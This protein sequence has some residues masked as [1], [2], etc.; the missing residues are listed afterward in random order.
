MAEPVI[1]FVAPATLDPQSRAALDGMAA[2]LGFVPASML[3]YFHR[4]PIAN[5]IM[6]LMGA[7]FQAPDS[8]LPSALKGKLGILCS[9]IN[10]CAY[11]VSHQCHAGGADDAAL[12][13]LVS[14][15]D[16]GGDAVERAC[17]AY[18]RAASFDPASVDVA[19][20]EELKAVLSPAQIVELATVVGM[21][22]MINTIHDTLHLPVEPGLPD[23]AGL[24][25][26]A[27]A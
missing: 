20:L 1:P 7:V 24:I 15:A 8:A 5:A 23:A 2:M 21:W 19:M 25:A 4:P 9:A 10:G 26:A 13:A 17:F 16:E 11:C 12:L 14:G 18:A 3:T 22:K 27:R 6:A